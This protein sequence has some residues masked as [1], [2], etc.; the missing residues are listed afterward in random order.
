MRCRTCRRALIEREAVS[1]ICRRCPSARAL[2]AVDVAPVVEPGRYLTAALTTT[3][4]STLPDR[5]VTR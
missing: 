3:E 1:G 2:S 4:P 5:K